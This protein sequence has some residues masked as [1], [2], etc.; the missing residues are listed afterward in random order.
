LLH[1]SRTLA[2]ML[3]PLVP[4]GWLAAGGD[5]RLAP[6]DRALLFVWFL[7]YLGLYCLWGPYEAWWYTR[8]LLPAFPA[9]VVAA[10]LV[11]RDVL[12]LCSERSNRLAVVV[13]AFLLLSVAFAEV[14]GVRRWKPLDIAE[15]EKT[16]TLAMDFLRSKLPER[17]LV[18]VSMQ[19]SGSLRYYT[20]FAPVRWDWLQPGDFETIAARAR[21]KGYPI[22][23]LLFAWEVQDAASRAPGRWTFVG[24]VRNANLWR[25]D[26]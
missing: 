10:V 4:L 3:S 8:F 22:Y 17:S 5:R 2:E 24:K 1:Y 25:L 18:V 14:R 13:A 11:A 15:G 12:R 20:D 7:S 9:V 16:Y 23:A 19:M 26:H 6:R 21:E